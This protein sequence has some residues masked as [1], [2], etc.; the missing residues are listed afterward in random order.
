MIEGIVHLLLTLVCFGL[1]AILFLYCENKH[2]VD[3]NYN[4]NVQHSDTPAYYKHYLETT[5]L[6]K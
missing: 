3:V 1:I 4:K 6:R 2:D 5:V